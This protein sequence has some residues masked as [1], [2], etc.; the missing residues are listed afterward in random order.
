[1]FLIEYIMN[2]QVTE[3]QVLKVPR[4][5]TTDWIWII[6]HHLNIDIH[7]IEK[8][9]MTDREKDIGNIGIENID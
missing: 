5:D 1:M 7:L 2:I 6:H 4:I 9:A 3:D 8:E